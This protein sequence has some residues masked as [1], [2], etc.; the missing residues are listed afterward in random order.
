MDA[1]RMMT[2]LPGVQ[3]RVILVGIHDQHTSVDFHQVFLKELSIQ[4]VR[5]YSPDDFTEAIRLIAAGEIDLTPFISKQYPLEELQQAME[6]AIS[7]AP[8][9]KTLIN[10]AA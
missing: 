4:G 8:V 6:L 2:L 1:V 9:I 7:G 5:A 10:F 3:G